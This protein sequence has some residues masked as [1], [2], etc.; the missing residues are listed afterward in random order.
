MQNSLVVTSTWQ[1]WNPGPF[2]HR[3]CQVLQP[4]WTNRR[5]VIFSMWT[6]IAMNLCVTRNLMYI[7]F[8]DLFIKVKPTK[9]QRKPTRSNRCFPKPES[10]KSWFINSNGSTKQPGW[11]RN[12]NVRLKA[13]EQTFIYICPIFYGIQNLL[14]I[15]K[16]CPKRKRTL[17]F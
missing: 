5:L 4:H 8:L 16:K 10:I 2:M 3:P 14:G 12:R 13:G 1:E 15:E 17:T 7:D 11:D 9:N 6:W